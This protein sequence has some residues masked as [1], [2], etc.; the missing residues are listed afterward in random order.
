MPSKINY[1]KS[2]H[3]NDEIKAVVSVI[4]KSTQMGDKTKTFENKISK[5]FNKKYGLMVNSGSSAL[6]LAYEVLPIPKK[7]N[8]I[9][10]ILTFSTTVSSMI[11]AG[12]VPNFVDVN[13]QTYCI[14]ENKIENRI[15]KKTKAIAVPNL[16]GNLPNWILIKKIAKKYNLLI[17]EDS[18]DALG[19]TIN[20]SSSGKNSDI[21]ITSFY[22]SH[23]I[24][25]AGNG[26]Y[27]GFNNKKIYQH[28]KLLRSWGRSSSL[29]DE[30][31]EKIENRFNITI[32]GIRYD[33]KFVFEK[34]G[35]NFEPS[36]IG[37][38]FGLVQLKKLKYNLR[39]RTSVFKKHNK[40]FSN[41][42][43][44]FITPLQYDNVYTGWLAYPILI[45]KNKYF[46]RTDLQIFLEK[47]QIQ[48]RVVFTGNIL[49]Q[50][51]F[52]K[53]KCIKNKRYNNA[54]KIMK[55]ALLIGCHHDLK[56]HQIVYM[57]KIIKKFIRLKTN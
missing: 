28:A 51:G 50:P 53:I 42:N 32:D 2:V 26:G 12:F 44:F 24:N 7:S 16:L 23:I 20:N 4:K 33:K 19:A 21:S 10:P 9:T 43:N 38:A 40:F 56:D 47:N 25:C 18:A 55:S 13:L 6:L 17:I 52:T 11:K 14:D 37:A 3:G 46:N 29:Y 49:R 45:K 34:L 35:Y 57:H 48:T 39:K 15:N 5:L 31:S 30:N 1:G 8:I 36:E 54:D 41:L 22:G 27:L